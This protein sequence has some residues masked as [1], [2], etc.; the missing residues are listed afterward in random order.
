MPKISISQI[1]NKINKFEKK[2]KDVKKWY[3][4]MGVVVAANSL[5]V[6]KILITL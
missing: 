1:N 5:A 6:I 3:I 4:V 2:F